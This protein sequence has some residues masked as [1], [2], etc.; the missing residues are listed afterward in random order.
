MILSIHVC[1]K[2][3]RTLTL[4]LFMLGCLSLSAQ[5]QQ[6]FPD[7]PVKIIVANP[8]GG[9]VD[10]VLRVL[11]NRMSAIWHQPVVVEN[12]PGGAGI[13]S[14]SALVKAAPDGYTIAM[15][16]ASSMTIMPFAVD[17]LPYDPMK[18]LQPISLVA[19]TP[20]IFIVRQDSPIKTWQDFVALAKK[21]DLTIG[22]YAI[23]SAFHLVWEQTARRVGIKA[24]YAPANSAGKTQSDLVGGQLDIV[25]EAPSS[26]NAMLESGRVRAIAI[27]SPERF[28]GLP[29]TPT[30]AESGLEG[31]ASLPWIGLMGPAG[32]PVE[33]VSII[34]RTVAEILKE[35]AMQKQLQTLGMISVGSDPQMLADTILQE[36]RAMQPLVKELGI[37]LQ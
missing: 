8:P 23:G 27:T 13:V 14:T 3:C 2:L 37:K 29:D 15:V 22:S 10:V 35:P 9:P 17:T 32:M 16:T 33:R 6:S 18:D 12:K 34:Q 26:A 21:E 1:R 25:L 20:F 4:S 24:V 11:A 28:A 30:L 5:A 19:R 7:K 36:R 31:Y